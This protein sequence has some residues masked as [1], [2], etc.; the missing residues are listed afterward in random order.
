MHN[1]IIYAGKPQYGAEEVIHKSCCNQ[2]CFHTLSIAEIEEVR[3]SY[4]ARNE[5]QQAQYV[6]DY[7]RQHSNMRHGQW[8]T[9]FTIAGKTVCKTCWRLAMGI[10]RSRFV[11]LLKKFE[12]GVVQVE[13][14]RSGMQY[15]Q[16]QT[17]TV[18]SWMRAFFNKLGDRLP[19]QDS[20]HLPSCLT[21]REV[22]LLAK[23]DLT[24]AGL[25]CCGHATFFALWKDHFPTVTIPQVS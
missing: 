7:L 9:L 3:S 13:H 24:Q 10:K 16:Q 14:G 4:Y 21:K 5:T 23:E 15:Q 1:I 11:T 25:A 19:M 18:V 20:I 17:I 2:N 6:V 22:Y 12:D 8:Q